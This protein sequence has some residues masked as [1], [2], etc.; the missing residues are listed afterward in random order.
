MGTTGAVTTA[1]T[2]CE[3]SASSSTV[4]VTHPLAVPLIP[5]FVLDQLETP[6]FVSHA[7]ASALA[8]TPPPLAVMPVMDV[9]STVVS[10]LLCPTRP[11]TQ[12][13]PS[14]RVIVTVP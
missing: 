8:S 11:T 14:A 7:W 12:L 6:P 1:T 2:A 4:R 3:G 10:V 13:V 5:W 9:E